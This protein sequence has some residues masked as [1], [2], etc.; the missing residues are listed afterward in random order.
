M[1]QEPRPSVSS[2]P[3][4]IFSLL[5]PG[6]CQL[7][8]RGGWGTERSRIARR[9]R[10]DFFAQARMARQH[11][12]VPQEVKPRRRYRGNQAEDEIF[13]RKHDG[14]RAVLPDA[15]EL[16]LERAVEAHGEPVRRAVPAAPTTP[17]ID[18]Q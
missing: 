15:L 1:C 10:D 9:T 17:K 14:A 13:R 6:E 16:E 12:E 18:A 11:A 4:W 8:A 7:I 3:L 5:E 2:R